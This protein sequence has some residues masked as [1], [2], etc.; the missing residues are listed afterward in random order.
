MAENKELSMDGICLITPENLN[1]FA[2]FLLPNA[3]ELM[4]SGTPV[5]AFG[6]VKDGIACGA[7]AGYLVEKSF[8]IISFYVAPEY[9]RYGVGSN[10]LTTLE[11]M[12]RPY[13]DVIYID[14]YIT[15]D[16]H[17][18]LPVLLEKYGYKGRPMPG[19]TTYATTVRELFEGKIFERHYGDD[20]LASFS[21]I[22][23]NDLKAAEKEAIKQKMPIP[24]GGFSAPSVDME[25]S[26]ILIKNNPLKAYVA[27]EKAPDGSLVVSGVGNC[28]DTPMMLFKDVDADVVERARKKYEVTAGAYLQA[29]FAETMSRFM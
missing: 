7:I 19:R 13:T 6:Y 24:K 16:E 17:R 21:D 25:C 28:M 15:T 22:D 29:A 1:H 12:V 3:R 5:T 14:F 26:T 27:I 18:L 11:D 10:L 8:I 4:V 20:L 2:P 23:E 9:R